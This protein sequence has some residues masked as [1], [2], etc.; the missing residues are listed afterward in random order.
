[1]GVLVARSVKRA[2]AGF[3][4]MG[5]YYRSGG[6]SVYVGVLYGVLCDDGSL[7]KVRT[8]VVSLIHNGLMLLRS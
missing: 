8:G 2:L 6:G 4:Y 3:I 1:M 7:G 5:V